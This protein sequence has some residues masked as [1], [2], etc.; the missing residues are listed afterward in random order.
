MSK[1]KNFIMDVQETVW[2]FFDED[3]N[4]VADTKIK[5]KDDLIT[6]IKTKFGSMGVDIA[7]EEIFAIETGDHFSA[8]HP[9]FG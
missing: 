5:T 4:F 1:I 2:D 3:G 9:E 6:D 7:K 8:G